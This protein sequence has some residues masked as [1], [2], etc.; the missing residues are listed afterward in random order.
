[1][2]FTLPFSGSSCG[3]LRSRGAG[4][5]EESEGDKVNLWDSIY[6]ECCHLWGRQ[7]NLSKNHVKYLIGFQENWS[8]FHSSAPCTFLGS[9]TAFQPLKLHYVVSRVVWNALSRLLR[10]NSCMHFWSQDVMPL[11]CMARSSAL[12]VGLH[13][14]TQWRRW[15]WWK[16]GLTL[17]G[18]SHSCHSHGY[19]S[20]CCTTHI[21]GVLF[22]LVS[23]R[24]HPG[25]FQQRSMKKNCKNIQS[26]HLSCSILAWQICSSNAC[27][28]YIS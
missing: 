18:V 14:A 22:L 26:S 9:R 5:V 6:C 24:S 15:V 3:S 2:P 25:C 20:P 13:A 23:H 17:R 27:S 12:R 28:V 11:K 19:I 8:E 4:R 10:P 21:R 7:W 1:M 16:R